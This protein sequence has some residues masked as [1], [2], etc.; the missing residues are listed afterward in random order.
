MQP[1]EIQI[2][3]VCHVEGGIGTR[4][5]LSTGASSGRSHQAHEHFHREG[6][7]EGQ[8]TSGRCEEGSGGGG[9]RTRE[10]GKGKGRL[11]VLQQEEAN[12]MDC[13]DIPPTIPCNFAQELVQLR[14]C[15]CA[16]VAD[17]TGRPLRQVAE[18][19]RSRG[20]GAQAAQDSGFTSSRFGSA[21]PK[22]CRQDR[23]HGW[24]VA[25]RRSVFCF[26]PDG[27]TDRKRRFESSKWQSFQPI[28]IWKGLSPRERAQYGLRGDR[29]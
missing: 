21:E 23:G 3:S 9:G 19:R 13:Q 1:L 25:R 11:Q 26:S 8:F 5:V 22:H 17:G 20:Q 28:V 12:G 15:M 29:I 14:T 24:P 10:V 16:R 18:F 6:E 4:Q 2:P 27:D 7:E